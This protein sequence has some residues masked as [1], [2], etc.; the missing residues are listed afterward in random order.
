MEIE[1]DRIKK[2]SE[3]VEKRF[4]CSKCNNN[5]GYYR[6]I[7]VTGD[8]LTKIVD[9]QYNRFLTVSCTRCGHTDIFD[10]KVLRDSNFNW[11]IFDEVYGEK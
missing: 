5:K 9:F 3:A 4:I 11:E 7:S 10:L 6:R 8:G 1:R 2:I